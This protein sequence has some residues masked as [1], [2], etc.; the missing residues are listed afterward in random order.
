MMPNYLW[1]YKKK[2]TDCE[3]L[4]EYLSKFGEWAT[5]WPMKFNM[6]KC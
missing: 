2:K 6:G 4:Q 1:Q 5:V 3:E